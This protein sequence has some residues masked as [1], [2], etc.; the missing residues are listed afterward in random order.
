MIVACIG[1]PRSGSTLQFEICAKIIQNRCEEFEN[2]GYLRLEEQGE[3]LDKRAANCMKK[4]SIVIFKSHELSRELEPA[5]KS[6][7]VIHSYRDLRDSFVSHKN[8]WNVQLKDFVMRHK[9]LIVKYETMKNTENYLEQS[10]EKEIFERWS[11][12]NSIAHFLNLD[13]TE[14]ETKK[15]FCETSVDNVAN[16]TSPG[17]KEFLFLYLN[18]ALR[19]CPPGLKNAMRRIG[20]NEK[21]RRYLIP[22]DVHQKTDLFH[23]DHISINKGRPGVW[24][25]CLNKIE[26]DTLENEFGDWLR[27]RGYEIEQ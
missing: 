24:R 4:N 13:V 1:F 8:K 14:D 11:C 12:I 20:V 23:F 15:I 19:G 26:K 16:V 25:Q 22:H 5:G 2:L 7:Y 18:K 3:L 17:I 6:L 9:S 21:V 27:K 10:Y